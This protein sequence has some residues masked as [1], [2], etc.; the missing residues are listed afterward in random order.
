MHQSICVTIENVCLSGG[1]A[2]ELQ[3]LRELEL[4][5]TLSVVPRYAL[6]SF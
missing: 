3:F 5:Y 2:A 4:T 6:E 1:A